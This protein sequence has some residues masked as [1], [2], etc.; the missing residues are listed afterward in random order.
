ME[1]STGSLMRLVGG[2]LSV[3]FVN[4]MDEDA[5]GGDHLPSYAD[6]RDWLRLVGLSVGPGTIDEVRAVREQIDA[7]LRPL[8]MN[9]VAPQ[10]ALNGLKKIEL[11][12][13]DRA[14]MQPGGWRWRPAAP[15]DLVIH[16]AAVLVLD[17]PWKQLRTCD[18]CSWIFLDLSRNRLRR[19]CSM[20]SCGNKV[21]AARLTDKRRSTRAGAP[22][23]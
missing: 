22:P 6:F 15:L 3:D 9:G 16:D 17:G 7:V 20:E 8:A 10:T 2:S 13:L 19:W 1:S 5:P 18:N 14:I 21:K 4:T 23:R 11:S 12:A